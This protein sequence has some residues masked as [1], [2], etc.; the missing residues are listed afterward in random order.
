MR[1]GVWAFAYGLL[2]DGLGREE[3]RDELRKTAKIAEATSERLAERLCGPEQLEQPKERKARVWLAAA[4]V[5]GVGVLFAV[6]WATSSAESLAQETPEIVVKYIGVS[7]DR[8]HPQHVSQVGHSL[9]R[10]DV[11][12]D[13]VSSRI[14]HHW[15]VEEAL[16]SVP[17]P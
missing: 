17:K 14:E 9:I 6:R 3:I 5:A 13:L 2:L 8:G 1:L 10:T 7:S 12:G 15:V 16:R 4:L 11:Q